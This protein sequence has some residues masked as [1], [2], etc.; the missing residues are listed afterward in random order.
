MR[1]ADVAVRDGLIAVVGRVDGRGR[2]EMRVDGLV[3]APGFVDIHT[4]YDGQA[5][6]DSRLSPSS[7]NGV[8]TVVMGN[9]GVGFAPVKPVHRDRL[10]DL[11]EGVEDIPGTALHE[12]L[13]WTWE[14]FPDFLDVLERRDYDVDIGTQIPH[15]ALRVNVMGERAAAREAATEDEIGAMSQAAAEA[16]HAGALGFS[17]SRTL[18]HKTLSG[19]LTPSYGAGLDEL[20]AIA[21]AIGKTG[22]GVLQLITDF[23]DT[24]IDFDII[25]RMLRA[26][27]RP[28]SFSLLQNRDRPERY[29]DVLEF[30]TS[31]NARGH[32]LRA[33]VGTRAIGVIHGL[34]SS[35][36][37]F[38]TNTVWRR[39]LSHLSAREQAKVMADPVTKKRILDAQ[40]DEQVL[41]R[42][43]GSR[44]HRWDVMYEFTDPP[45]YE[46]SESSSIAALA[47]RLGRSP[48]DIAY[49][50]LSS[51]EGRGLIYQ[52]FLNYAYGSLDAVREMLVHEYTI[53]GLS[54]GGAHV[55]TICD[56]SF[57]T[58][59]LQH[60]VRD[61]RQDS[62][63]LP[64]VIKRQARD[65]ALAVGLLDRGLLRPGHKA[66]LNVIEMAALTLHRPEVHQDLPAG[67]RRLMQR[68]DGYRHTFVSGIETYRDGEPTGELP[69]R[70]V[71][72][73]RMRGPGG[74]ALHRP[75]TSQSASS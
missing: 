44:I 68:A 52:P 2:R 48:D 49:D 67:G 54:D 11:M 46:P 39:E 15:A 60:W 23:V 3:V 29:R 37:P 55:G 30:L 21:T 12:G 53:P 17:T 69:G 64:F 42:G 56:A 57:P 65:T 10:I 59:L 5:T 72:G 35:L 34:A 27:G 22:T 43:G 75:A 40:T 36:N 1:N 61:R 66:D 25:D 19:E 20:V 73:A 4:H 74:T 71:R 62:L 58:T 41:H 63:D 8:T 18:N 33:Q 38:M 14:S 31:M 47:Q 16:I 7:W 26:S 51:D 32:R 9:C 70:L 45:D 13:P 24:D 6:W 28:M 50:I